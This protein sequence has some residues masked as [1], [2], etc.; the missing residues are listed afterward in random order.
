MSETIK[1]L[2]AEK[3]F[4]FELYIS[5]KFN[6]DDIIQAMVRM[7]EAFEILYAESFIGNYNIRKI[8]HSGGA[9]ANEEI[10]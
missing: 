7:A 1:E 9:T 4:P 5:G 10:K 8:E 2:V 6:H 3:I